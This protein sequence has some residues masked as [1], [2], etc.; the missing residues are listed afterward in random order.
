MNHEI[1]YLEKLFQ[2]QTDSV[3][4]MFKAQ[5]N[6][7]LSL[8][9]ATNKLGRE[10]SETK[11]ELAGFRHEVLR[12]FDSCPVGDLREHIGRIDVELERIR[13]T[14]T[15]S[16]TKISRPPESHGGMHITWTDWNVIL[17]SLPF[18]GAVIGTVFGLQFCQSDAHVLKAIVP[19]KVQAVSHGD[20]AE[21]NKKD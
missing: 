4:E 12:H 7:I 2:S 15:K 14:R 6:N 10:L 5:A 8:S 9:E 18:V 20:E 11:G 16:D 1:E 17:K 13:A 3:R 19:Q 21:E